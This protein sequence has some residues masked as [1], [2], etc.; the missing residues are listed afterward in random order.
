MNGKV[1]ERSLIFEESVFVLIIIICL[2]VRLFFVLAVF[3]EAVLWPEWMRE[4]GV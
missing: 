4:L 1:R 2:I 3:C